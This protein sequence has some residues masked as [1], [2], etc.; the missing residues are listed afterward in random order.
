MLKEAKHGFQY[1]CLFFFSGIDDWLCDY[2]LVVFDDYTFVQC[3]DGEFI[4]NLQR[5]TLTCGLP[6]KLE[7]SI[8]EN[9][10]EEELWN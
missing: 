8:F 4:D 6:T 10:L 5:H 9:H 7:G 3:P 1:V 2:I